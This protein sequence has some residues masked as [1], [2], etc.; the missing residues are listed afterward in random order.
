AVER[1]VNSD[2]EIPSEANKQLITLAVEELTR[3][4][5][6]QPHI[7]EHALS[8]LVA[9]GRKE[10]NAVMEALMAH[11]KEGAVAHFMV[12]HCL[13]AMAT[14]NVPDVVPFIKPILA[15]ILPN[16]GGIKHDHIK[17]AHA[18][19][20]GH[21]SEALLEQSSAHGAAAVVSTATSP[22]NGEMESASDA[23]TQNADGKGD[24]ATEISVAY[25]VLFNQW[26]HSRE[27]K[28]CVEILQALSSMYPLLPVDKIQDQSPR[29][30]PQI[31][32]LYRR[33]IE[34]NSVTQFLS[35]V[36]KTNIALQPSVL[37]AV[38]D[39]LISN[40]FDLVCVFPDYEKPQTVK[41]HYEVLR[42]FHLLSGIYDL[43]Y[44]EL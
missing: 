10:C 38:A 37:D 43:N 16:L 23:P 20:I 36:L 25:D 4:A 12:M 29:L 42:C 24:C 44:Y 22:I 21:F 19:A 14:A 17:Q 26:L 28:V 2:T 7:Q 35:S 8:I 6:H 39:Q 33:S 5:E 15:T 31:L 34:R 32:A 9:I 18:Y 3:S 13:G 41:G 40:L 11:T 27:P 1:L 30:M